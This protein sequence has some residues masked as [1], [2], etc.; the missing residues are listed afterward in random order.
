MHVKLEEAQEKLLGLVTHLPGESLSLLQAVGRVNF[1]N[2]FAGHDLPPHRQAVVDG[3][4]ISASAKQDIT[5]YKIRQHLRAGEM[6]TISLSPGEAV[7]VLTGS[8]LPE[9]TWAV[10]PDESVR[11]DKNCIVLTEKYFPGENI[12]PLGEDFSN[13]ELLVKSG[14]YLGPGAI[15]A[16]AAYG[17]EKITVFKQPLVGILSLGPGIVPYHAIPVR[18]QLRDSNGPLLAAL[19][20]RNG[21]RVSSVE[22]AGQ[23]D[24]SLVSQR[25]VK[26]LKQSDLIITTGG[27]ARGESDQ[28]TYILKQ[29]GARLL[30]RGVKIKPG[31]HSG[32]AVYNDK[33]IILLSGNPAACFTGYQLLAVPVLRA[34]QGLD[35]GL[36]RL[37]A[38]CVNS[39]L[40]KGGPRR[41]LQACA[42]CSHEGWKVMCYPG[43]KNSMLKSLINCNSLIDLPPGHQPLEAGTGVSVILLASSA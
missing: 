41:F 15:G 36:Q 35:P 32:A 6:P 11:L 29:I 4:A 5:R 28:A 19:V 7:G 27:T 38:I 3:Y 24:P 25:L 13:G 9:G 12:R 2:C 40:K 30:F 18:G 23:G 37:T 22:V 21:G 39:F 20:N 14:D 43:Q 31:S 34:L 8:P 16:L 42:T 10:V 17:I 26:I 1:F 33:L